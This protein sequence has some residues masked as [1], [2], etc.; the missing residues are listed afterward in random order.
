[1]NSVPS[2]RQGS[3]PWWTCGVR[4]SKMRTSCPAFTSASAVWEPTNPAP[5]VIRTFFR[6]TSCLLRSRVPN[7]GVQL[8]ALLAQLSVNAAIREHSRPTLDVCHRGE[9]VLTTEL[10]TVIAVER[11]Q[12]SRQSGRKFLTRAAPSPALP[13]LSGAE[14]I[15]SRSFA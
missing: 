11:L 1:M 3:F 10:P 13:W 5:P 2:G 9:D 6:F 7:N 15:D 12:S 8:L 14:H 4:L